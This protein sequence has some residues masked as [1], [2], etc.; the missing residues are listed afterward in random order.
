MGNVE[1]IGIAFFPLYLQLLGYFVKTASS[2]F[3]S[4]AP[5]MLDSPYQEENGS[6]AAV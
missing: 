2:G 1:L 4:R 5:Y 6:A 3:I